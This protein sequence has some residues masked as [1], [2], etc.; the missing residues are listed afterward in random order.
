MYIFFG[1]SYPGEIY[2]AKDIFNSLFD[3]ILR[4]NNDL[5]KFKSIHKDINNHLD[6]RR[7]T[8]KEYRGYLLNALHI[9]NIVI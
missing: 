9:C 6:N 5:E 3:Q 7:H 8:N 1:G 4:L 2:K